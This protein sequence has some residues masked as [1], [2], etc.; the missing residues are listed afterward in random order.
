[1]LPYNKRYELY[2]EVL[3]ETEKQPLMLAAARMAV[4]EVKKV[5]R[6]IHMPQDRR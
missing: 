4:V 3:V 2:H 1:M 5:F 6:R